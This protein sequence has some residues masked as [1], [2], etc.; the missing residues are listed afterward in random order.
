M[1]LWS[2][3]K[4]IPWTPDRFGEAR[5]VVTQPTEDELANIGIDSV[6]I[7]NGTVP[8]LRKSAVGEQNESSHDSCPDK[9][10]LTKT[11]AHVQ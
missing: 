4:Q 5:S 8:Q 10:Q 9:N 7:A 1:E 3:A 2:G 11:K 6:T